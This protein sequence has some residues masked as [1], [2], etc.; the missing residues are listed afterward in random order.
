MPDMKNLPVRTALAA[1]LTLALGATAPNAAAATAVVAAQPSVTAIDAARGNPQLIILRAGVFDPAA[2]QLDVRSVGAASTATS[3][4]AIVQFKPGPLAAA[5]RALV[6]RGV[7][8]LGYV[9]NN[10]YYARL[11]GASLADIAQDPSVRYAGAVEPAMKLD[12]TLWLAS[13]G[14]SAALQNDGLYELMIEGYAG[15]SSARIESVLAKQVP[16]VEITMRS[17]RAEAAPYVRAKVSAAALD[18]LIVAATAIDGVAF[19]SPWSAPHTMNAG[20]IGALQ[21]NLSGACAGSGPICG[22]AP[23]FDQGLTGSGQ[24]VAVADSGTTPNAAWFATLDKGDGPHTEVTFAENPPPVPPN[25]GTLHTDNKII[26]YW[27]QPGG[28]TDYDYVSGHGTH[29]TGTVLGDA[30]GTFGSNTFMP[31]TPY[32]PNHDLADGMAPNAQLLMQD[33]GP[34]QAT[35]II[36]QDFEGTM[37]QAAAAG[38]FIHSNSW[39]SDNNATYTAQDANVDRATRKQEGLLVV[40]AAGNDV[41]GAMAVGNPGVSKNAV[42]VAALGHAG[43]LV[44]AGFS[45]AGPTADGRMKPDVAAPGSATVSARNS[46]SSTPVSNTVLAPLTA[47]NSGTSMATPT[48]AGN[49]ALLRQ[50]FSD[51]FYPRGFQNDGSGGNDLIFADGFEQA[52]PQVTGGGELVD[53]YNPTGSVLKAVLLNGTVQTTSPATFPNTGTG[54]GRP[55]LDGN[56]WFKDTQPDG[57]DSRRLRV[58]ERTNAS[59][60][61]TGE[62]HEYTIDN[63]E[64]G[65]EF[66]ATLTWF[67]PAAAAGAVS[68]LVNNLDLEVVAPGN[69]TY[70][71]NVFSGNVSVTGGT[72]DSKDTVEQV[73]FTAPVA[74]SYTIRVKA[75]S[76]P[77]SGEGGSDRQGYGLAV[78]GR[79]GIPD[80]TPFAAPTALAVGPNNT[81]GIA[82]TATSTAGA[83]SYQLYRAD[84]ATCATAQTGDFHLVA[85]GATL[86]LTDTRSQGGYSYAYKLRGVQND[87]E[88]EASACIDVVSADD[89]TLTP[90]FDVHSISVDASNASCSVNVAWA[91]AQSNCPAASAITYTVERDTDPYFGAPS[92]V[93]TSLSATTFS[94][95]A[96]SNG[97]PYFYRVR[98]TDAAGN[99]SLVSAIANATPSGTD[100]PDPGSF[101]DDVDTH[102]YMALESPWQV[103]D[104]AASA[105]SYSY[106]AGRDDEPYPD[107]TCVSISTPSMLLTAGAVLSMQAKY[108]L[109]HE[110]DGVVQE[111][112]SDGGVTWTDLPPDGGYPSSFAQTTNPPVNACA[113]PAS[114][115]AFNGVT[116]VGSN[117]DPG[118]GSAVAVFKPFTT[119]L[120]SYVGQNVMIRWRFSSDPASAFDGFFLDQVQITG[121]AGPGSYMCTP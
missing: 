42:T 109:E 25:I 58:F 14:T 32:L 107:N 94:D 74:G 18:A 121:A 71:G 108:D 15:V 87:V 96:V 76:V 13:R 45:N 93:G 82:V 10:A 78:S 37:L 20:G 95:T 106:R 92:Q 111:I 50:Y 56:L 19:V 66:R 59:G 48:V 77:G 57:D 60:L 21:A 8:L 33:V 119:S 91:E 88:G 46:T 17:E 90:D 40:I 3:G 70:L 97:T 11:N 105:G 118:N 23:L 80:P 4:Y 110:W 6:A 114:H 101:L 64:A 81:S 24:I 104:L 49:A 29:T 116:T 22:P 62:V 67:D 28:P 86:P 43:S 31:S 38:A 75:A 39:G 12:P 54:W 55:W 117:E 115:G 27:T 1:A 72:A 61:E 53:A 100:G 16:G 68:T 79:F 84:D 83:Q 102:S 63:I 73:R 51:G 120:A 99:D 85:H 69:Q 65:A 30:S 89:C 41:P 36:A 98:A 26:G 112:S 9:P 2:Q 103:T 7:E 35:S 44:K 113:Y 52:P 47:S 34:N 5:R